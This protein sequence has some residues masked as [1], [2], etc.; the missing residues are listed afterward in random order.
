MYILRGYRPLPPTPE[1][2]RSGLHSW[3]FM[4][5]YVIF[6]ST[7]VSAASHFLHNVAFWTDKK[8]APNCSLQASKTLGSPQRLLPLAFFFPRWFLLLVTCRCRQGSADTVWFMIYNVYGYTIIF[9][10]LQHRNELENCRGFLM[11]CQ[12]LAEEMGNVDKAE[13]EV[14]AV[15]R[16]RPGFQMD[17]GGPVDLSVSPFFELTSTW[18]SFWTQARYWYDR[19]DRYDRCVFFFEWKQ[20]ATGAALCDPIQVAKVEKLAEPV[21]AVDNPTDEAVGKFPWS[22]HCQAMSETISPFWSVFLQIKFLDD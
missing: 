6:L 1:E 15:P 11:R 12:A 20:F 9:R 4:I 17:H 8:P 2:S 3:Y 18:I 10:F 21:A 5:I 13:A 22:L 16:N 19:Y 7:C 14:P